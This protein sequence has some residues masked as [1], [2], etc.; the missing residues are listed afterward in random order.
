[1]QPKV[2]S[3]HNEVESPAS[4]PTETCVTDCDALVIN[5]GSAYLGLAKPLLKIKSISHVAYTVFA[6]GWA[7][8]CLLLYYWRYQLPDELKASLLI[9]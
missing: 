9:N 5:D 4:P 6:I 2:F 3:I 1:M 7:I 8:A